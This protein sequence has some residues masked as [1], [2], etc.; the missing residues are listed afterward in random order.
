[1][2]NENLYKED[3][4]MDF[5]RFDI[6]SESEQVDL[7]E[8]WTPRQRMQYLMRNTISE[9]ECFGPIFQ[10]INEIEASEKNSK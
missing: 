3:G 4:S 1:M 9:E 5:E 2:C 7:M 10:L 8:R 6:L